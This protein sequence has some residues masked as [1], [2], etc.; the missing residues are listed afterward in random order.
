MIR[1]NIVP[2]PCAKSAWELFRAAKAETVFPGDN[3]GKAGEE[4]RPG[5][6]KTNDRDKTE[7]CSSQIDNLSFG[8]YNGVGNKA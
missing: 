4:S 3:G 5:F 7:D 6:P 2:L 1:Q 8:R